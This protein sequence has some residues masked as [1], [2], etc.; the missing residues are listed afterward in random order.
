MLLWDGWRWQLT[1]GQQRHSAAVPLLCTLSS[2]SASTSACTVHVCALSP[3]LASRC[4]GY[5]VRA[6]NIHSFSNAKAGTYL[7]LASAGYGISLAVICL[8]LGCWCV[9]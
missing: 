1:V 7:A 5:A 8:L 2:G 3:A 6:A 4:V 9:G